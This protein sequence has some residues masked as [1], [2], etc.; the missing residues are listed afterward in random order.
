MI[1]GTSAYMA[2]EQA[3]GKQ[4]DKRADIWAFGV[5]VYELLTGRRL[6]GGDTSIEILGEV[7]NK[8]PDLSAVPP[9]AR[10]LLV[11]CLEK[12]PQGSAASDR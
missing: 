10:R 1:V 6:F 5:I 12:A 7:L 11:W 8:T 9:R 2:P 3:K 4:A